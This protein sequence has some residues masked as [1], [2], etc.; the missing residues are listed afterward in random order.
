MRQVALRN[1]EMMPRLRVV[2]DRSSEK[3]VPLGPTGVRVR[4]NVKKLRQAHGMTYRELSE[5]L[6]RLGRPIPVLGLSRLERG[7][8][9]VD[10]DDLV[11]LALALE[12][13]PNRLMLPDVDRPGISTR[14]LLT[15]TATGDPQELWTWAQG[16]ELLETPLERLTEEDRPGD[17][18]FW[19]TNDNK[20]YLLSN[21]VLSGGGLPGRD[22]DRSPELQERL[23]LIVGAA[24]QAL[25]SGLTGT[26]VRCAAELGITVS[27][28]AGQQD[29]TAPESGEGKPV[30]KE[31]G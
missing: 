16:E 15:P 28:N 11:A 29:D 3:K 25:A 13:T 9:R 23:G 12:V 6:E 26:E 19:F 31:T 1:I 20:P 4:A 17:R 30:A 22:A 27:R 5:R 14:W 18:L 24:Q 8:R 7:E 2:A 21:A 10:A